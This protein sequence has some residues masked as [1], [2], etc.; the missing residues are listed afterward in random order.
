[1][2]I[3]RTDDLIIIQI[4]LSQGRTVEVRKTLYRRIAE[5]L[6]QEVKLDPQN[7][8]VNLIEVAKENWSFGSGEAQYA[9]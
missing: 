4:T 5:L 1:M 6:A 9:T 8:F 3:H 2:K 7:V